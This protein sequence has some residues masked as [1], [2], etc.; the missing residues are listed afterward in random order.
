MLSLENGKKIV[1]FGRE[2]IKSILKNE[3]IKLS[4]LENF[5]NEK[6]GVFVT[7]HTYP[8]HMLRGCIGIPEP[9]MPLQKAIIEAGASVIHDPR[10]PTLKE[11]EFN[12]IIIEITVLTKPI[13]IEYEEPK[14]LLHKIT[15]GKD[16]LI[17]RYR[18]R[19]GLFL[20][21]VPVEQG[22]NVEEYLTN[23]CYKAGLSPDTWLEKD[24]SILYFQGQIFSEVKPNGMIKENKIQ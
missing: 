1:K 22:W 16:G 2:V 3:D 8:E 13:P 17:I 20:P 11:T 21:Q 18:G 19:I 6:S 15:I 24:A 12:D 9:I 23:L 7:I 10:F 4:N 14:E 5:F